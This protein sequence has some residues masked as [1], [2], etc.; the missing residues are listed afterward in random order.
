[1]AK[2]SCKK[3]EDIEV[4]RHEKDRGKN[5][6]PVGLAS[7]DTSKT[8]P[9]KYEHDPHLD[10]QLVWAG[11]AEHTSSEVPTVSLH[12]HERI[13]PEAIVS[14]LKREDPQIDLF[15]KPDLPLKELVEFYQHEM[16]W[17]NRLILGDSLLVMNSLLEREMMAGK[18]QCIYFDPPY[19]VK[20]SSNFQP[21]VKQRDVKEQDK[22]MVR[23]PERIK[24]SI[25][26]QISD[27]NL[28][29]VRE[30]TDEVFGRENFVSQIIF[31]K[32]AG[33]GSGTVDSL[34]D[35]ILW[36]A[37]KIDLPC[38][39]DRG[40]SNARYYFHHIRSL[41]P[42]AKTTGNTLAVHLNQAPKTASPSKSLITGGMR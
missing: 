27:E 19:G 21:S 29:H 11:K 39:R 28:H 14:S 30:L 17:T 12:I 20:F 4:Y 41:Y 9:K 3:K 42:V 36:Y 35:I 8:K 13:A 23:E 31:K 37:R 26:V 15:A 10:P 22:Y 34:H 24:G 25:F 40:E 1:M 18:V 2:R 32:T 5:V 38:G 6:V 33:K 16:D 7:Y